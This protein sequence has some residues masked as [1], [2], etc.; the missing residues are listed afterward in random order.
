[1]RKY[2]KQ[3]RRQPAR[4]VFPEG[5]AETILRAVQVLVDERIAAPVLLG[6]RQQIERR[7]E[8]LDLDLGYKV[9]IIEPA[10]HPSF[11]AYC[12]EYARLA[13]RRGVTLGDA[14]HR[15]SQDRSYFGMMMLRQGDAQAAVL[16]LTSSY[17]EALRPTLELVGTA[18][19]VER[20]SSMHML[21]FESDVKFFADAAVNVDPSAEEVAEIA[22]LTAD[23][24]RALGVT[25]RVAMVSFSTFGGSR[26]PAAR[27]MAR[28]TELVQERRPEIE[29]DGELQVDVALN[30][31]LQRKLY[32]FCRLTG[33]ANTFIFPNV[34]AGNA[35]CKML[36]QL[37]HAEVVGPMLLGLGRPVEVLERSA[38][39]DDVVR[40]VSL[41][42]AKPNLRPLDSL[43]TAA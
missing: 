42:A 6:S 4:V 16:G 18:P 36:A 33:P 24:V 25:P 31:T 38:S 3:A 35:C 2:R 34:D 11:E 20:V 43:R 12:E 9:E 32:P 28:A 22:A 17:P 14:R 30:Y 13:G 21:V 29:V 37:G 23:R 27:K 39:V 7:A 8:Q 40:I 26:H 10:Q 15:L 41:L 19:G 1:M 5:E